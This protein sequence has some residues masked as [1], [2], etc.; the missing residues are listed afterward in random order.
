[1]FEP[2]GRVAGEIFK[3]NRLNE[4]IK[5]VTARSTEIESADL[6]EK[7]NIIVAEVFDTELIG[8][9]ALRTFKEA[10]L[11]LAQVVKL[12]CNSQNGYLIKITQI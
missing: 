1:M 7:P 5:L 12:M 4:R 8:E 10:L 6:A 2:M 11:N 3:L 9:G